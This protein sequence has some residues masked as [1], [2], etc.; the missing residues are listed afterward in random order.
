MQILSESH[1]KSWIWLQ[2][3]PIRWSI[4][5]HH[6][7]NSNCL[8]EWGLCNT[9]NDEWENLS[10]FANWECLIFMT[11]QDVFSSWIQMLFWVCKSAENSQFLPLKCFCHSCLLIFFSPPARPLCKLDWKTTSTTTP[12]PTQKNKIWIHISPG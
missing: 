2:S 5:P 6:T 12:P 3:S 7:Y 10:A 4:R 1:V 8:A 11:S 9:G